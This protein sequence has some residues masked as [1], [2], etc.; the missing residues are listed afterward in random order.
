MYALVTPHPFDLNI[1][2]SDWKLNLWRQAIDFWN[3]AKVLVCFLISFLFLVMYWWQH[4]V[5]RLTNN[6]LRMTE[7]KLQRHDL[8][9]FLHYFCLLK[10]LVSNVKV[11]HFTMGSNLLWYWTMYLRYSS[12]VI[13]FFSNLCLLFY[14]NLVQI[15]L[16]WFDEIF[17]L[18]LS[19]K[20]IG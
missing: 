14:S 1:A 6:D 10:E 2:V 4:L 15:P 12:N 5:S 7:Q 16:P 11:V 9:R 19:A 13:L 17:T 3:L 8:T 18:F 20:G